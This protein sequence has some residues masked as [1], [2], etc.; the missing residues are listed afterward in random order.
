M[1]STEANPIRSLGFGDPVVFPLR[2]L[3]SDLRT[4]IEDTDAPSEATD[5]GNP[6]PHFKPAPLGDRMSPPTG[7]TNPTMGPGWE[8]RINA[9]RQVA[10]H[11][12]SDTASS[13]SP[14]DRSALASPVDDGSWSSE[15]PVPV[16]K[17]EDPESHMPDAPT[18]A[19][20]TDIGDP[21]AD[22][23]A[24]ATLGSPVSV[25][26]EEQS[27]AD[28]QAVATLGSPVSVKHEEQSDEDLLRIVSPQE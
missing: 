25:K 23:Q 17:V 10:S 11:Q 24:V 20:K 16:V 4:R 28:E 14:D 26:Q 1:A 13:R 2:A 3:V 27:L 8:D 9:W 7:N 21:L 18:S 12:L 15:S 6:E 22:E 19:A 5:N